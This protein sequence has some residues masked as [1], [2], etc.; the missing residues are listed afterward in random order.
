M[1]KGQS[2]L[3]LAHL[4][5]NTA[6]RD[7]QFQLLKIESAI[8]LRALQKNPNLHAEVKEHLVNAIDKLSSATRDDL[9][10]NSQT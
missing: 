5:A 4:A 10:S 9:L 1:E 6:D 3:D 7:K 2:N 8:V